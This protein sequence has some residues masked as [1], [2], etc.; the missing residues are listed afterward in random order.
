M[1]QQVEELDDG[2]TDE[3]LEAMDILLPKLR[4]D[5]LRD[6]YE[7]VDQYEFVEFVVWSGWGW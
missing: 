6:L 5:E 7:S 1:Q 2:V 3:Q 4:D